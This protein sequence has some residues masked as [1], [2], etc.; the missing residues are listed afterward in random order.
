[1]FE[2]ASLS[3]KLSDPEFKVLEGDL[4]T[5]LL[6]TQLQIAE[7][8]KYAILLVIAGIDGAGKALIAQRL[9]EWL[10]PRHISTDAFYLPTEEEQRYPRMRRYWSVLPAKGRMSIVFGSWYHQPLYDRITGMIDEGHFQE[11]MHKIAS[12]E[13]LLANQGYI[14]CKLWAHLP[15]KERKKR[16]RMKSDDALLAVR[17]N[18]W[19]D[20]ASLDYD[21]ARG[22]V[23]EM[24]RITST[25]QAPWAVVPGADANYRDALAGQI[26]LDRMEHKLEAPCHPAPA[27]TPPLKA[28]GIPGPT[29]LDRLDLSSKQHPRSYRKQLNALQQR[30]HKLTQAD[31]FKRSGMIVVFE[32]ADAAGKGGCIRRAVRQLDP[33]IY[34]IHSI[35]APTDEEL[36]HPY[37]WRFWR[38]IPSQGRLVI[39]DRSWYGRVLVERVEGLCPIED[40]QRAYQEIADFEGELVESKRKVVKFW[41]QI[42]KD[43]QLKRF[44]SREETPFKRFK[45]TE[46]DWRNR[47][48]WDSYQAAAV[49]MIDRT[50]TINAPWVLVPSEDKKFARIKILETLCNLLSEK[51]S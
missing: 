14:L 7:E 49:E 5:R 45:I 16:A 48:N 32:G 43:E 23:E 20:L 10:D 18:E 42:S 34:R 41:L 38:R 46:E 47:K 37:L 26:L 3:R 2:S 24:A 22:S 31:D 9:L 6:M 50:S 13:S 8:C 25:A 17:M 44:K 12:F 39:F 36:A 33:R 4:R 27:P 29:I 21:L 40:W 19:G 15:R 1:M 30:L 35:A 28:K 51:R 11:E